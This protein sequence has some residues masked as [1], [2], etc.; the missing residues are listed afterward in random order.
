M[1]GCSSCSGCST[2]PNISPTKKAEKLE[3][4]QRSDNPRYPHVFVGKQAI[5]TDPEVQMIVAVL[6]D[7]C[8]DNCDCFTLNPLQILRDL[9]K[10][11]SLGNA[12]D[13]SQPVGETCWKLQALI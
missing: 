6:A 1:G 8:D 4:V 2:E 11:H 5:Y 10:K 3:K 9:Q 13:V 12:I 7:E